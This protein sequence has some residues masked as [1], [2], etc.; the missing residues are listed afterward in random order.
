MGERKGE[1]EGERGLGEIKRS[2]GGIGVGEGG[3]MAVTVWGMDGVSELDAAGR[4]AGLALGGLGAEPS[5]WDAAP[6]RGYR[7]SRVR[8]A[9]G[10]DGG[11]WIMRL[12]V[13]GW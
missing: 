2:I 1:R 5:A 11:W 13:C 4:R 9:T 7:A 10:I 12:T 3:S 8:V 6:E